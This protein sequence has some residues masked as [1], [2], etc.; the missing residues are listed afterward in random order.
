[1]RHHVLVLHYVLIALIFVECLA[2]ISWAVE[3]IDVILF[4]FQL[5]IAFG[6]LGALYDR[7]KP[8]INMLLWAG[9]FGMF[10]STIKTIWGALLMP[11]GMP[12]YPLILL[13]AI[14]FKTLT[15]F[16]IWISTVRSD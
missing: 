9:L 5:I 15:I 3:F 13:I 4:L 14:I 7:S 16:F 12:K 11:F 2:S 1:M 10:L 6:L 8:N